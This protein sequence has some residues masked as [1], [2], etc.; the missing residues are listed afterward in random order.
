MAFKYQPTMCMGFGCNAAGVVGCRIID[1][2][3]ERLIGILTNNF[4][5]CNGRFPTLIAILTMF[6]I[7]TSAGGFESILSALLLTLVILLGVGMTFAV[8][9]LLSKTI[10]KGVLS[11]FTLELPPYRRPQIGRII[12]RSIFDRTLFVLGRAIAVAAPAGLLIWIMA[13][14]TVG[15]YTLLAHCSG[16][17]DPFARLF[18]MDGVILLA[19]ILGF[20][21]NEIVFPIIIMAYMSTGSIMEFERLS[22]LRELLVANDWTWITAVSTMLFSLMHWPCSTSCLT[23]QK[24]TKSLKWT[25]VSLALPTLIGMV[26]CFVFANGAR[27][28][29]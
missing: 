8:S 13:N 29:L 19:F 12:V 11:S 10:L 9:R 6:F 24:E 15:D 26:A 2:P 4:V 21:A 17:L 22:D 16:F 14:V 25:A 20:P 3:R 23:I 7:G 27:L 5:P 18:G 28:F 1:S